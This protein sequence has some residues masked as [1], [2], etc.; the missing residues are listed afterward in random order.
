[1][2]SPV[3]LQDPHDKQKSTLSPNYNKTLFEVKAAG[4]MLHL[5]DL[6][7]WNDEIIFVQW[8]GVFEKPHQKY[9]WIE[10]RGGGGGV[11]I[12]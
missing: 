9:F 12:G 8:G 3:F 7:D 10:G 4:K 2:P 1:M 5:H 11:D 6:Y